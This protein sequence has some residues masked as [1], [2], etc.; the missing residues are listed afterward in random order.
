ML[1]KL[2]Y[3]FRTGF[4]KTGLIVASLFLCLISSTNAQLSIVT[5]GAAVIQ[6]FNS[7]GSAAA[8]TL[9]SGFRFGAGSGNYTTGTT[10]TTVAAGTSGTGILTGTSTGGSY[11]FANGITATSTDRGI[12]FISTGGFASPREIMLQVQNNTGSTI[13]DLAISWNYEKYRSGT[14]AFNWTFF[15]GTSGTTWSAVTSGDQSYAADA[16][17]TTI[18]NPPLGANKSINVTGLSVPNGGFYYLRWVY[19]GVG[20]S[21]NA[22]GLGIDDFSITAT[23]PTPSISISSIP[24]FSTI[25]GQTAPIQTY[26]VSGANLTNNITLQPFNANFEIST[27]GINFTTGVVV[28]PQSGGVVNSTLIYVRMV[29][30]SVGTFTSQ[31]SH[32]SVGAS[33]Q[34]LNLTGNIVPSTWYSVSSGNINGSTVWS[35]T[36]TG[37]PDPIAYSKFRSDVSLVI[38]T[39]TTILLPSSLAATPVKN[40]TIQSGGRLWRNSS[41]TGNMIYLNIF[42]NIVNNGE[43]GNGTT[44]DACGFQI[45]GNCQFSGTGIHNLGRVRKNT[46]TPTSSLSIMT[47]SVNIRFPGL[48]LYNNFDNTTLDIIVPNGKKLLLPNGEFSTNSTNGTGNTSLMNLTVSG[49]FVANGV[50]TSYGIN[51]N[52]SSVPASP[53]DNLISSNIIINSSGKVTIKNFD[54]R[55][56]PVMNLTINTGGTLT[57]TGFMRVFAGTINSNG[58]IVIENGA[59]LFSGTG[60]T[61]PFSPSG[62]T[63]TGNIKVK[64]QGDFAFTNYN[65]WSS[66]ITNSLLQP[67]ILGGALAGSAANIYEYNPTIATTNPQSGWTNLP[68][69]NPMT[70]GK[71]YT[72]TAAGNVTFNGPVNQTSIT[73]PLQQGPNSNFNLVGNP[74]PSTLNITSFLSTNGLS[75][76]YLW[77][78]DASIG[79][80]YQPNDYIVVSS[81]GTVSGSSTTPSPSVTGVSSCQGFFIESTN[82]TVTFNNTMR[83]SGQAQ[84]FEDI[85]RVWLRFNNNFGLSTETLLAFVEDATMDRD[86]MYDAITL[87]Q[88]QDFDIWTVSQDNFDLIIQALPYLTTEISIPLGVNCTL[89]GTQS[90]GLGTIENI[91][92]TVLFILEDTQ[93]GVFHSL[94]EGDYVWENNEVTLGTSRFILHIK[95][96]VIVNSTQTSCTGQD[97]KITIIGNLNWNYSING[98][99]AQIEDTVVVNI[100]DPGLYTLNLING[101]Y[102]VSKLINITTPQLVQTQITTNVSTLFVGEQIEIFNNTTGADSILFDYGDDSPITTDEVYQYSL[103]GIFTCTIIAKN[104][105]CVAQDQIILNVIEFP[106]SI[107]EIKSRDVLIYPNPNNGILN[108]S[109]NKNERVQI[110]NSIGQ[111]L[112]DEVVFEKMIIEDLTTGLYFVQIGQNRFKMFMN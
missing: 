81:L 8:A 74:Y 61:Y 64:K 10:V 20:G 48:A 49:T 5:P 30:T 99:S 86:P 68:G 106:N 54:I 66:P 72:A 100:T 2:F 29:P 14:R 83:Q 95:P 4:N 76:V 18:S 89:I 65:F 28:L 16:N 90:I 96:A 85:Q 82:P 27:D 58:G 45:E 23:T 102:M 22:Q 104:Q 3:A 7:M 47:D 63:I 109:S 111:L 62:G 50:G 103:P 57:I 84:F 110:Y 12:G 52:P 34:N 35:A 59:N 105:D 53:V 92:E 38:Q 37:L 13:S 9:P 91:D 98:E 60:F 17:N 112:K 94:R 107:S 11:N 42:G 88:N 41:L 108:I 26:T 25:S 97:G 19:T 46:N 93:L 71:G 87:G 55:Q 1:T 39:G 33:N 21:T 36:P 31:I 101:N 78:D 69:S 40:L 15:T 44:F 43:I 79:A 6:N 75:A 24:N 80:D 32:N 77:D 73:L 70:P 56:T 67:L 51:L